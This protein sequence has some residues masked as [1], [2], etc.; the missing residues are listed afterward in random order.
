MKL[1]RSVLLLPALLGGCSLSHSHPPG[2]DAMTFIDAQIQDSTPVIA[3]AQNA[4]LQASGSAPLPWHTVEL[5]APGSAPPHPATSAAGPVATQTPRPLRGLHN[6]H[7]LGVPGNIA[8]VRVHQPHLMLDDAL[9]R[10]LPAG[11][12][13]VLSADLKT[14]LPPRTDLDVND[15]WPY[16]LDALLGQHGL[17][18]FIDWPRQQVSVARRTPAFDAAPA[19]VT[20]SQKATPSPAGTTP[21]QLP[22]GAPRN[23]FSQSNAAIAPPSTTPAPHAATIRTAPVTTPPRPVAPHPLPVKPAAPVQTWRAERG[24]TLKDT[25]T[26]WTARAPCAS[27]HHETWSLVWQTN[28]NYRIDAPLVFTGTFREALNG[29]FGL[30]IGATVPLYAGTSTPQCLLKVDDK[31]VR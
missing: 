7:T 25:L 27:G 30:Y 19:N 21:V 26:L 17:V 22:S 5:D 15:Q 14:P 4:L 23:P 18:A 9:R 8:L 29:V 13:L 11:W 31:A 3:L 28:V 6:V 2:N 12:S 1:H 10:L 16:A 20:P 24:S